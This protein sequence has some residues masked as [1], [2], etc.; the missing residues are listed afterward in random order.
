[1][2][3]VLLSNEHQFSISAGSK[4]DSK[5]SFSSLV[6]ASHH[7][8]HPYLLQPKVHPHEVVEAC[9][10]KA[11]VDP[12]SRLLW[13]GV[14]NPTYVLSVLTEAGKQEI[15]IFSIT[16]HEHPT[17]MAH[18]RKVPQINP[19]SVRH[20]RLVSLQGETMIRCWSVRSSVG[21]QRVPMTDDLGSLTWRPQFG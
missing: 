19:S 7:E 20:S 17:Y 5:T 2:D 12:R 6:T 16:V 13:T 8:K 1:M 15:N 11:M 4:S 9:F 21:E 14:G 3:Y 10:L 18:Q